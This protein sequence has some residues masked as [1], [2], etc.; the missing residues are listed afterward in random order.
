MSWEVILQAK[1]FNYTVLRMTVEEIISDMDIFTL[2]DI[3]GE[4]KEK[5]ADK[6]VP[7][8]GKGAKN[9]AR[10]L[11]KTHIG[12][13]VNAIGTHKVNKEIRYEDGK[14]AGEMRVYRRIKE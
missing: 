4:V 8:F 14:W 1:A 7:I 11:T 9:H 3:L 13:I 12:N 6:M 5:Y 10:R 2:P